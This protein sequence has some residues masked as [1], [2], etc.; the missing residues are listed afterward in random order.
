LIEAAQAGRVVLQDY[1]PLAE[2][3]EWEL[4]ARYLERRGCRA[5]LSDPIPVPYI[6]NNTGLLSR[7]A[8]ELLFRSLAA[9]GNTQGNLVVLELGIG[10]GLFARYF[11][12]AFR[13]LC[14]LHRVD[15]YDRLVYIAA[16]RS[17]RMLLDTIRRGTFQHHPGRYL[18]R[19]I[20]ALN[21]SRALRD[22]PALCGPTERPLRAV[23]LNYLLDCLPATVLQVRAESD[24]DRS[25]GTSQGARR[26]FQLCVRTCLAR[27]IDLREYTNDSSED[28]ARLAASDNPD[29]RSRL[30]NVFG[31]FTTEY[32]YRA[33]QPER[34]PYGSFIRDFI[35]RQP[36]TVVHSHGAIACLE[37]LL[38]LLGPR[39][40]IL[41]ND[42]GSS[43]PATQYEFEH[44][45]Y[46]GSTFVG[47]NFALLGQFF[48]KAGN[49]DKDRHEEG[50]S[51]V[52]WAEPGEDSGRIVSRL[53]GD[54]LQAEV[55]TMFRERF[56]KVAWDRL[57]EP[58]QKAKAHAAQMRYEAAAT[59]Y[60]IAV[61]QQPWNWLLL[62]EVAN[63]LT[64]G[65]RDARAGLEV[66]RAGLEL[67]PCCSAELWN[68][69]GDA[70]F[71]LGRIDQARLAYERAQA[72]NPDDV[73][74]RYN[75]SWVYLHRRE[76]ANALQV[77]AEGL[78]KDWRG[79]YR[80][81]LLQKQ[82]EVLADQ[83]R[84]ARQEFQTLINRVSLSP[85]STG[86]GDERA[87]VP[88]PSYDKK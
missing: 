53:L 87:T 14:T 50:T 57:E 64:F 15:Y 41:I 63:F 19:T 67:N 54:H 2:S 10:L 35:G 56:T 82:V 76:H 66:A 70:L 26:L 80:D 68:A 5:F 39:G 25:G 34:I 77:I 4:G 47:V 46:T 23:F 30:L 16:D 21:P 88:P 3:L 9:E 75:L 58:A 81:R 49:E 62:Q 78:A 27:G 84:R 28:L 11:L 20:D 59:A 40:F 42:Y 48:A 6:V 61:V 55:V 38:D 1:L 83:A 22:D 7:H 37:R 86:G 24:A 85:R 72:V 74:A 73:Q 65:L 69:Y 71:S 33:I 12:D 31:L 51:S 13:D 36:A 18:L 45:R 60:R 8:A 43:E 44:Q 32:D 79:E 29:D 52:R 17:E